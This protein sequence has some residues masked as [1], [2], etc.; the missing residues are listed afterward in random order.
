M[1]HGV[2]RP[3]K[4]VDLWHFEPIGECYGLLGI[5]VFD[6]RH[7]LDLLGFLKEFLKFTQFQSCMINLELE[8]RVGAIGCMVLGQLWWKRGRSWP[9]W[10]TR[11]LL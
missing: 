6:I 1:D 10:K 4:A 7:S 9:R 8:G 11:V 3:V 5:S 2:A